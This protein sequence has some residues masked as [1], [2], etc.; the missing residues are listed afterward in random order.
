MRLRLGLLALFAALL[1]G[2]SSMNCGAS[3]ENTSAAGGCGL[4]HTF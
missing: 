4:H 1:A 2:C 3:S